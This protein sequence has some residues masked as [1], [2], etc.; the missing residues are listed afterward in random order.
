MSRTNLEPT[1]DM[2]NIHIH[3]TVLK[4]LRLSMLISVQRLLYHTEINLAPRAETPALLALGARLI[5][6][7]L[8]T[9][10]SVEITSRNEGMS[11]GQK[12]VEVALSMM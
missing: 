8:W 11:T 3:W 6:V 9:K 12:N 1:D 4:T 7:R 5:S 2:D 10:I